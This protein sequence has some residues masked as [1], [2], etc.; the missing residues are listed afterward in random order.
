MDSTFIILLVLGLLLYGLYQLW[1]AWREADLSKRLEAAGIPAQ[2]EVTD[3]WSARGR[4]SPAT[5][6]VIYNFRASELASDQEFEHQQQVSPANYER[7]IVETHPTIKYLADDPQHT[8]RL[9]GD[10]ADRT[11]I[12]SR[13]LSGLILVSVTS[14]MLVLSASLR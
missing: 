5:Y 2:A 8:A 9:S 4:F 12:T 10:F 6:Y 1:S 14:V 3:R 11:A 13:L 7:L